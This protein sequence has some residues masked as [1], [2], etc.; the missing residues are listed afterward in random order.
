[1]SY[2]P[3]L[4]ALDILL[5]R[6][7]DQFFPIL[8]VLANFHCGLR[9]R[10]Q[11]QPIGQMLSPHIR[12]WVWSI[13]ISDLYP[14]Q[15]FPHTAIQ[16]RREINGIPFISQSHMQLS[17]PP[18]LP[19]EGH[20]ILVNGIRQA[21]HRARLNYGSLPEIPQETT[22]R[23]SVFVTRAHAIG[24]CVFTDSPVYSIGNG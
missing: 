18:I 8:I 15:L 10:R 2:H 23:H 24:L 1:M 5:Y 20:I 21:E 12:W 4:A 16:P 9:Q 6:Q 17:L 7:P 14:G 13:P 22:A 19:Q 3:S 11:Y